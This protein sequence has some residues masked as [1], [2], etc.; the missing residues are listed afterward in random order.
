MSNKFS[1]R[2]VFSP[3]TLFFL[4]V[5]VLAICLR[6]YRLNQLELFGD[7]LDVGYQAYSLLKTRKDYRGNFLPVYLESFSESRAPFFIYSAIPFVAIFGL[8]EWGIRLTSAFW[9]ILDIVFLYLLVRLIE[10]D[11]KVAMWAALIMTIIPWHLHYSRAGFEVTLLLFL[12]LA[13]TYAFIKGLMKKT[14]WFSGAAICFALS[15][16]TYNTANVFTSIWII[17]LLFVFRFELK[18]QLVRLVPALA[19]F[20]LILIPFSFSIFRGPAVSRFKLISIFS[21]QKLI[22]QII[23]KRSA[24]P[25]N[26][27]ERFFHNK[28]FVWSKVV[29]KNYLTAFS[30]QFLFFNGDP[31][32]RHTVPG[33]G[34]IYIILLFFLLS[35]IL[36][37]LEKESKKPN[38]WLN[39]L[40][41]A[42]IASA[43][44]VG[45]GEQA[46]RLF[47]MVPPLV[48]LIAIGIEKISAK[49]KG[50]FLVI[51]IMIL[52]YS[53]VGYFHELTKHYPQEQFR[54]WHFGY[55]EAINL[56]NENES[57]CRNYFLNN[58][59]EPILIRYLFWTGTDPNWFLNNFKDDK[60]NQTTNGFSNFSLGNVFFGHLIEENRL[61]G[62][63]RILAEPGNCYLAF[64]KDEIPGDWNIEKE[65]IRGIKV[66][67]LV[68]APGNKDPY[69][70]LLGGLR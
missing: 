15:F 27:T 59:H 26:L 20:I 53:L 34:E 67:G 32:P 57:I 56:V 28:L 54:Y 41:I 51:V 40:L 50:I 31:N 19:I 38:I 23:L 10:K 22:E 48:V 39:W 70:Y 1:L 6:I 47:L 46:T 4:V 7:E 2:K 14:I 63:K 69:I 62:V 5:L 29:L 30:P 42:P 58:S 49:I 18:T 13:G 37:S 43:L 61:E 66:L 33:F 17:I 64:Q 21:D 24:D 11:K 52:T 3:E 55:K 12:I 68:K 25:Q 35:G 44:T 9:G 36:V 65:P 45:G 60:E 8:N 16:Y